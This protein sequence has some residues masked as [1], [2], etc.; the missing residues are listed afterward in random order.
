MAP[1]SSGTLS[2]SLKAKNIRPCEIQGSF[3]IFPRLQGGQLLK[4]TTDPT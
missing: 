3:I 2:R 4:A 1:K